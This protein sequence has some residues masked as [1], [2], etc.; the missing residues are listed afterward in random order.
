MSL[1]VC[2]S[3]SAVSSS[4][5]NI[6]LQYGPAHILGMEVCAKNS[7][8]TLMSCLENIDYVHHEMCEALRGMGWSSWPLAW[9]K[10]E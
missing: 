8:M 5:D 10:E 1:V 2:G 4:S 3:G 9:M 6:T 7:N